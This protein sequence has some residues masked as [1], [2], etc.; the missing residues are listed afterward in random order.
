MPKNQYKNIKKHSFSLKSIKKDTIVIGVDEAG[1]GSWAGPVVAACVSWSGRNPIKNLLRD[2]KK[3][4]E[5]NREITYEEIIELSKKWK[6]SYGV[7]IISQTIIDSVGIREA[8][9]QAMQKALLQV[10]N[11]KCKI[12]N[13]EMLLIDGRDNYVFDIPNLLQPEYIIRGDDI[14]PQIMAASIVAKVTRDRLMT[15]YETIFPW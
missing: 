3:M 10:Q 9:R 6:L 8:N 4:N 13:E 5:K 12:Q 1:R 15:E 2:S 11:A 14:V 7:G